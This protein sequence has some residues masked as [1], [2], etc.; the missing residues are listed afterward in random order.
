MTVKIAFVEIEK[1]EIVEIILRM[2]AGGFTVGLLI[3]L[4]TLRIL[5]V[6]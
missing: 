3:V 4:P 1:S 6:A 2:V 5:G